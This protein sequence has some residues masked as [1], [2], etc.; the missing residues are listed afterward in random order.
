MWLLAVVRVVLGSYVVVGVMFVWPS[1]GEP[2]STIHISMPGR[3]G[4]DGTCGDCVS[5]VVDLPYLFIV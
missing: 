1:L 2:P 3:V 4:V 5:F